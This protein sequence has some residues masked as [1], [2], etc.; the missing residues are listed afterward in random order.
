MKKEYLVNKYQFGTV[1]PGS[2]PVAFEYQPLGLEAF[3]QPI[4]QRQKMFDTTLDALD[5]ASFKIDGFDI[6]KESSDKLNAELVEH[7]NFLMQQL[8]ETGNSKEI[9]RR[10]K[11]LNKV[12]NEDAEIAGIRQQKANF[13]AQDKIEKERVD[14]ENYT[15]NDYRQWR[16]K[17][18]FD[19][20]KKGGYNYDRST[21][22]HNTIDIS[23]RGANLEKEMMDKVL[24]IAKSAPSNSVEE[25]ISAVQAGLTQAGFSDLDGD[26]IIKIKN[27]FKEK[28]KLGNEI[29]NF[30]KKSDRYQ[31][32]LLEKAKYD[33]HDLTA[34]GKNLEAVNSG[35]E[36]I[37]S[38]F[39]NQISNIDKELSSSDNIDEKELQE[40]RK[41]LIVA[42]TDFENGIKN[43]AEQG[44]DVYYKV[45]EKAFAEMQTS[46]FKED[47]SAAGADVYDFYKNSLSSSNT[48]SKTGK[49]AAKENI[50][51]IH[52]YSI[53]TSAT[54]IKDD[55]SPISAEVSV[56][57][58]DSGLNVGAL[59]S[60]MNISSTLVNTEED[61]IIENYNQ[62]IE[63]QENIS[64]NNYYDADQIYLNRH[65]PEVMTDP[66]IVPETKEEQ[67]YK[68]A[69]KEIE[70][71]LKISMENDLRETKISHAVLNEINDINKALETQNT[72][73]EESNTQLK[74]PTNSTETINKL[75]TK[76]LLAQRNKS[77]IEKFKLLEFHDLNNMVSLE[78]NKKGN[79]WMKE[80]F[81]T[82]DYDEVY[83]QSYQRNLD[84]LSNQVSSASRTKQT[85]Y[86]N[87]LNL[88]DKSN[89]LLTYE[90]G[91]VN[92]SLNK[93]YKE[94]TLKNT[95][96]QAA[97]PV[98]V[99]VNDAA[100]KLTDDEFKKSIDFIKQS[101]SGK[102]VGAR[103][104]TFDAGTGKVNNV[105][106]LKSNDKFNLA[107][108]N[109]TPVWVGESNQGG[110][111][112][113]IYLYTK[114]DKPEN[115]RSAILLEKNIDNTKE[116]RADITPEEIKE[117]NDNNPNN[118]YLSLEG[119][120][121]NILNNAKMNFTSLSKDAI[122]ANDAFAFNTILDSYAAV[123]VNADEDRRKRYLQKATTLKNALEKKDSDIIAGEVPSTW[124]QIGNTGVYKG[125]AIDYRYDE[126]TGGIIANVSEIKADKNGRVAYDDGRDFREVATHNL[127]SINSQALRGLDIIYGVGN[128]NDKVTDREGNDFV[129]A[130]SNRRNILNIA[131]QYKNK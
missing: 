76:I 96:D 25:Y 101:G 104:V 109:S 43:A 26:A 95:L 44:E 14:G 58:A 85:A 122:V 12:Y 8:Q 119:T 33:F 87:S 30:V 55:T 37:L 50:K 73:I 105:N 114:I 59:V 108:Y 21:G 131:N 125:H 123:D 60:D 48:N 67:Q 2:Q 91:K 4:A 47:I 3:A 84:N 68:D 39:E 52:E 63:N 7:K 6:D 15:Q 31:N 64:D 92:N 23:P 62:G 128:E 20:N 66:I 57:I 103:Q 11:K 81:N 5:S 9:A 35:I 88:N 99:I 41:N 107:G 24:K 45:A 97:V 74:D 28:G 126:E 27:E 94:F 22:D 111:S 46:D 10:L 106:A 80:A 102:D 90:G 89:R 110:N 86:L 61:K 54:T 13:L 75:S 18:L 69:I 112:H 49:T 115:V 78:M 79:E 77:D 65:E 118:L 19:Y 71:D 29:L 17:A 42:K 40:A 36:G 72:I 127:T 34:G 32:Y 16:E 38:M 120:S 82:G 83:K 129:P 117:F 113:Q 100:N 116:N 70:A 51:D 124:V 93:I 1:M 130:F 56:A 53:D 121:F 98:T